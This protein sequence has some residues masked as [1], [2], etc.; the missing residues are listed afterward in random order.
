MAVASIALEQRG[1]RFADLAFGVFLATLTLL[2]ATT[3]LFIVQGGRG[4]VVLSGSMAPAIETGDVAVI[5]A[6]KAKTVDEGDIITFSDP[7]RD[8]DLVTHRVIRIERQDDGKLAFTTKGDANKG[9]EEWLIEPGGS[10]G[11]FQFR[12]PKAGY[13]MQWSGRGTTRAVITIG[14]ALGATA[15][16]LRKIWTS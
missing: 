13:V 10:V 8:G 12:I 15:I 16:A 11:A 4:L 5:K 14:M 6:A 7:T 2:L 1:R 3:L 9:K